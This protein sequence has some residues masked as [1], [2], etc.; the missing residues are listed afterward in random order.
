[1]STWMPLMWTSNVSL[2]TLVC[3]HHKITLM[4]RET[5]DGWMHHQAP[6]RNIVE[7]SKQQSILRPIVF[8]CL[9]IGRPPDIFLLLPKLHY[10]RTLYCYFK[11]LD[12][13]EFLIWHSIRARSLAPQTSDRWQPCSLDHPPVEFRPK[14][15]FWVE[16]FKNQDPT[17]FYMGNWGIEFWGLRDHRKFRSGNVQDKQGSPGTGPLI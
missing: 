15:D 1:M 5:H 6:L 2:H 4:V 14:P 13:E 7:L 10:Y 17:C 3:C 11:W 9:A 8:H 12:C 16:I